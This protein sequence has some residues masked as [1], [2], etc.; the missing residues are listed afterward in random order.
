MSYTDK[1]FRDATQIAYLDL[2]KN[3]SND[4]NDQLGD[5]KSYTIA[6]LL[7]SK[8]SDKKWKVAE[9][10]AKLL[11]PDKEIGIKD[12][13]E[14][15]EGISESERKT[16][17][18]ISEEAFNWKLVAKRDTNNETGFYGCL[19][20]TGNGDA[21]VAFRGSEGMGKYGNDKHDWID[22]DGGLLTGYTQQEAEVEAFTKDLVESGVLDNYNNISA[23]GHSLG[24]ELASHFLVHCAEEYPE[25][26]EKIE[27]CVNM[28]GPGHSAKY[29]EQHKEAIQQVKGKYT[30]Y[31]WSFVSGS[32]K[33]LDE[34][35][36]VYLD[37][38]EPEGNLASVI[39][40]NFEKH[41]TSHLIF[42][43]NG[44]AI[45]KPVQKPD[46]VA[47]VWGA[48][49]NG[50][51]DLGLGLCMNSFLQWIGDELIMDD[52]KGNTI[53]TPKALLLIAKTMTELLPK[54]IPF[55]IENIIP[56][57]VTAL[58]IVLVAVI[59][60]EAYELWRK[61]GTAI[62]NIISS[63]IKKITNKFDQIVDDV[64]NR[65]NK[66]WY[67]IKDTV[68][69]WINPGYTYASNN[70]HIKINTDLL[71]NYADR[72]GMLN[73]R[74]NEADR[75]MNNLYLRVGLIDMW[76]LISADIVTG[77]N[78]KIELW[79]NFLYETADD[80]DNVE[81]GIIEAFL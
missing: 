81:N 76:N 73:S 16:L 58:V 74:I 44:N 50:I 43:E 35:C 77:Y 46:P 23:T 28:D 37:V 69:N 7:K 41:R 29:N 42:D 3:A 57:V 31:K 14:Y 48:I 5:N 40:Y 72:L 56:I 51:D 62:T 8:I 10:K 79:K 18:T 25:T 13:I 21:I 52:G 67:S 78:W 34:D 30:H 32:L 1:Q 63:A 36:V 61:Y 9:E 53:L 12:I 26:C 20:D 55:I 24:G 64:I 66:A 65:V 59:V 22:A 27:K 71:R 33:P 80:F 6:E 45:R 47:G 49:T 19:L 68:R 17:L 70:P 38:E 2:I 54:I 11:R 75:H 39:A 4:L 60:F 15:T